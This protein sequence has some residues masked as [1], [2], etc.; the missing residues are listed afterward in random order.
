MTTESVPQ[1]ESS[2]AV[3]PIVNNIKVINYAMNIVPN[4]SGPIKTLPR[5]KPVE[6]SKPSVIPG[7]K[8]TSSKKVQPLS[9][10]IKGDAEETENGYDA[11]S[12]GSVNPTTTSSSVGRDAT[13]IAIKLNS[14]N[15]SDKLSTVN[16]NVPDVI[17]TSIFYSQPASNSENSNS[18]NG[19]VKSFVNSSAGPSLS[20]EEKKGENV[21]KIVKT[22]QPPSMHN[23][24]ILNEIQTASSSKP[25]GSSSLTNQPIFFN[26]N[27]VKSDQLSENIKNGANKTITLAGQE[28]APKI[29]KKNE[30]KKVNNIVKEKKS[31]SKQANM[32]E[33]KEQNWKP[34]AKSATS[35]SSK[36]VVVSSQTL[37]QLKKQ[38]EREENVEKPKSIEVITDHVSSSNGR[39]T[40]ETSER[41]TNSNSERTKN[42]NSTSKDHPVYRKTTVKG[43]TEDSTSSLKLSEAKVNYQTTALTTPQTANQVNHIVPMKHDISKGSKPV[44]TTTNVSRQQNVK[45][46]QTNLEKKTQEKT[47]RGPT[48]DDQ[49]KVRLTKTHS[50]HSDSSIPQVRKP[51]LKKQKSDS[52]VK[53]QTFNSKPTKTIDGKPT[54][55]KTEA[56]VN[57]HVTSD[58]KRHAENATIIRQLDP[59]VI[60]SVVAKPTETVKTRTQDIVR[61]VS[62]APPN[63]TTATQNT[64]EHVKTSVV[65]TKSESTRVIK[66]TETTR[67]SATTSVSATVKTSN[68]DISIKSQKKHTTDDEIKT[69]TVQPTG[70]AKSEVKRMGTPHAVTSSEAP[71]T[72]SNL[73]KSAAKTNITQIETSH[74]PVTTP[75]ANQ[76]TSVTAASKSQLDSTFKAATISTTS[77]ATLGSNYVMKQSPETYPQ[78]NLEKHIS[79]TKSESVVAVKSHGSQKT[80]DSL[81]SK[82]EPSSTPGLATTN[83]NVEKNKMF[84]DSSLNHSKPDVLASTVEYYEQNHT[85]SK[86]K[87]NGKQSKS[88]EK[89]ARKDSKKKKKENK[90]LS[91]AKSDSEKY[92]TKKDKMLLSK[93]K[94]TGYNQDQQK[95]QLLNHNAD[96][97]TAEL[98]LRSNNNIPAPVFT[99]VVGS[100]IS[101]VV[102]E[103]IKNDTITDV[104]SAKDVI[105]SAVK[106]H[107]DTSKSVSTNIASTAA[108]DPEIITTQ[109]PNKHDFIE[110]EASLTQSKEV[111]KTTILD[112]TKP[113][114]TNQNEIQRNEPSKILSS[115]STITTDRQSGG[116]FMSSSKAMLFR[117]ASE[118]HIVRGDRPAS[119][120]APLESRMSLPVNLPKEN[121]E[122][123]AQ[124]LQI[125]KPIL[126]VGQASSEQLQPKPENK[127][128]IGVQMVLPEKNK[129]DQDILHEHL[130]IKERHQ[131]KKSSSV[132]R[133]VDVVNKKEDIAPILN[134]SSKGIK[135]TRSYLEPNSLTKKKIN[136]DLTTIMPPEPPAEFYAQYTKPE[137]TEEVVSTVTEVRN[138]ESYP[139]PDVRVVEPPKATR[140]NIQASNR[141]ATFIATNNSQ[142]SVEELK[143]HAIS[144]E[145][146][147][148]IP[149]RNHTPPIVSAKPKPM[150][151]SVDNSLFWGNSK[152]QSTLY[153]ETT[154][155]IQNKT[156]SM[157]TTKHEK[158][159]SMEKVEAGSIAV[160]KTSNTSKKATFNT[161]DLSETDPIMDVAIS[162]KLSK[163]KAPPPPVM[164]KTS[165]AIR[166]SASKKIE[167]R[168][169]VETTKE[170]TSDVEAV[171]NPKKMELLQKLKEKSS[172]SFAE[173]SKIQPPSPEEPSPE[174]LY[175]KVIKNRTNKLDEQHQGGEIERKYDGNLTNTVM[176][177]NHRESSSYIT[178]GEYQQG[179]NTFIIPG[180]ELQNVD[181]TEHTLDVSYESPYAEISNI[182]PASRP[183]YPEIPDPDYED[184]TIE[185]KMT[186]SQSVIAEE[187]P[188]MNLDAGVVEKEKIE[189]VPALD[190]NQIAV[191]TQ[192]SEKQVENSSPVENSNKMPV[193]PD[194]DY[195]ASAMGADVGAVEKENIEEVPVLDIN[196]IVVEAEQYSEK[197]LEISYPVESTKVMPAIPAPDYDEVTRDE[198]LQSIGTSNHPDADLTSTEPEKQT[199]VRSTSILVEKEENLNL[200]RLIHGKDKNIESVEKIEET[201]VKTDQQDSSTP[202]VNKKKAAQSDSTSDV[203]KS[204]LTLFK[205]TEVAAQNQPRKVVVRVE[206]PDEETK[207]SRRFSL[208]SFKKTRQGSKH[209]VISPDVA[210]NDSNEKDEFRARSHSSRLS[211]FLDK[212]K[213]RN[214]SRKKDHKRPQSD[215]ISDSYMNF[216]SGPD[217]SAETENMFNTFEQ[218]KEESTSQTV[219]FSNNLPGLSAAQS[220]NFLKNE[221]NYPQ[222]LPNT[223]MEGFYDIKQFKKIEKTA[224]EKAY[225]EDSAD[226]S[227][228]EEITYE[229]DYI[230]ASYEK[231]KMREVRGFDGFMMY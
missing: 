58:H 97:F 67:N 96:K 214:K 120:K 13:S 227:D 87:N 189:E 130:N 99:D 212:A 31:A 195:K 64:G 111:I 175:A 161:A 184:D 18:N 121:A 9:S 220:L 41:S 108:T 50:T 166:Y 106:K 70:T 71:T 26:P 91:K 219:P 76:N 86:S 100:K 88:E 123:I 37:A 52:A 62:T 2:H 231:R 25:T 109:L 196:Q 140:D 190:I 206:V 68:A 115:V 145:D 117:K 42:I 193:I 171:H 55:N 222:P 69:T 192:N 125:N 128:E 201:R 205:P 84:H 7:V 218:T 179:S 119:S 27:A 45:E 151:T 90:S 16:N 226:N 188:T 150:K 6:S 181:K 5:I 77:T 191:K 148:L 30:S 230:D 98:P 225:F 176:E 19:A 172:T 137:I 136:T 216:L 32:I 194:P 159:I 173:E 133:Y 12:P 210:P 170:T 60:S 182:Y 208:G 39:S 36:I 132:K 167:T 89:K 228:E 51:A 177:E 28:K 81:V 110:K 224:P 8:R 83:K 21:E 85:E 95:N 112:T 38:R 229:G 141:N 40:E 43:P 10:F 114:V 1:E 72:T 198:K 199:I 92:K 57:L 160:E 48:S 157:S 186:N 107:S 185:F 154:G 113:A 174:P 101:K 80:F 78:T 14:S 135:R 207:G 134:D 197:Q 169:S 127:K 209:A 65:K 213:F 131:V 143:P 105:H 61:T 187:A 59:T 3:R 49:R 56:S 75:Y 15:N 142:A 4:E 29:E 217:I 102:P 94:S 149:K 162:E 168:Y 165:K 66:T 93:Q 153:S 223:N 34:T 152:E 202:P 158:E 74:K 129:T 204:L 146:A 139:D 164:P 144:S 20:K 44:Y 11:F 104:S 155:M 46:K 138:V 53:V 54:N 35:A 215:I 33:V 122:E 203:P 63:R 124:S 178:T 47:K 116:E 180:G 17:P 73:K 126:T 118:N 221:N 163:R 147:E 183:S 79:V 211:S 200:Y 22:I 82:V 103:I 24:K 23:T 156:A